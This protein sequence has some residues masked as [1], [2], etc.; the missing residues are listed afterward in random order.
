MRHVLRLAG[1]LWLRLLLGI[2]RL[3]GVLLLLGRLLCVLHGGL[4]LCLRL[5]RL[6]WRWWRR[7]RLRGLL[8]RRRR[9]SRVSVELATTVVRVQ[10]A[11]VVGV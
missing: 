6:V 11:G 5:P 3:T 4:M 2:L 8:R 1:V 10:L 7:A 9:I